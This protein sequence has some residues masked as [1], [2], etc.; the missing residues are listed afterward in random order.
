MKKFIIILQ[1]LSVLIFISCF[2]NCGSSVKITRQYYSPGPLPDVN[3]S[4]LNG[5]VIL[6]DPGHGG[7][8]S[9]AV[10]KGGLMEKD[11]NL[12]VALFLRDMLLKGGARVYMT[13]DT[14]RDFLPEPGAHVKM[15]LMRRSEISD[16]IQPDLFLSI[17]HNAKDAS[18]TLPDTTKAFYKMG[19]IGPS[20]D[21]AIKIEKYFT[22]MLGMPQNALSF[23]NYSVLRNTHAP[24]V[25]GEPSFI[26]NPE[27]EAVLRD[28]NKLK[29]EADAYF[30]SA[31]SIIENAISIPWTSPKCFAKAC[32]ILPT[33]QPKSRALP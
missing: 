25:L 10:G 1:S 7:T 2:V 24:A 32:E 26:S 13:R 14:D 16:S 23:G 12:K 22:I 5:K 4:G 8:M 27:V 28:D 11:V 3:T 9:G 15:D 20:L 17:H 19:D 29:V 6:L 33:P 18:D 30:M 31:K 21:A